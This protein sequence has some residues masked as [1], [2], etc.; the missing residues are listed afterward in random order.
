MVIPRSAR[1]PVS[2]AMVAA[3]G[4]ARPDSA[5]ND[6]YS[7]EDDAGGPAGPVRAARAVSVV[8]AARLPPAELTIGV[9]S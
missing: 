7:G 1:A 3:C 5:G 4:L 8:A 9:R 2:A 6:V